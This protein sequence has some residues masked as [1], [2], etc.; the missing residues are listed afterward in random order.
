MLQR[1]RSG[2]R[3]VRRGLVVL[4]ATAGAIGASGCNNSPS[5]VFDCS[6]K[7]EVRGRFSE[8]NSGEIEFR[9]GVVSGNAAS[10]YTVLFTDD[11]LLADALRASPYPV[12]EV[13]PVAR[14]LGELVVGYTFDADGSLREHLTR[15]LSTS[16]G[17]G[18]N[19]KGK[20]TVDD[21]GCARGDVRLQYYG[22]GFFALPLPKRA[23]GEA[24]TDVEPSS[25]STRHE[26]PLLRYA[27]TH[28]RLVDRHPVI[29]FET[30]GFSTRVAT[31][32]SA[33]PRALAA[34]ERVRTQCPHPA[35]TSLNEYAEVVG[36]AEPA[37]GIVLSG[38][39]VTSLH[40]G[41][42]T[43]DNCYVMQ[44]NGEYIDQCWPFTTDCIKVP[45]YQS[46]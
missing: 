40:G 6:G 31:V 24:R 38:T 42:P 35:R 7:G 29:P 37:P 12:D 14:L 26:D 25:S 1:L 13:E 18:G 44:R 11:A 2:H 46:N 39:A 23:A 9:H 3:S 43:L 45:L 34:L 21:K 33:D 22:S 32:L 28:A 20:I 41:Q 15:G 10:G 36:P 5:S 16:S 27:D 19:D 30:L 4:L 17:S 8:T